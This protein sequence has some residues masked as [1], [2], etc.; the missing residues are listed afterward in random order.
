M[1]LRTMNRIIAILSALMLTLNVHQAKSRP[2]S[3][4]PDMTPM[5]VRYSDV[6]AEWR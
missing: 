2:S 6:I 4:V 5:P 3:D 1:F